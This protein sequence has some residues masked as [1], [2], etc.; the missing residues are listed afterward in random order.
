MIYAP[1]GHSEECIL[2]CGEPC[3]QAPGGL[4]TWASVRSPEPQLWDAIGSC[5]PLV[6]PRLL[7]QCP[8]SP[9]PKADTATFRDMAGRAGRKGQDVLAAHLETEEERQC[10]STGIKEKTKAN[11]KK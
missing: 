6:V 11:K 8:R 3:E 7:C 9:S 2:C 4:H 5:H 1:S 10:H